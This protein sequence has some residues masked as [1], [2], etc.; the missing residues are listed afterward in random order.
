MESIFSFKKIT[1]EKVAQV[2]CNLNIRKSCWTTDIPTKVMK[3]NSD[4][5]PKF[6]YKHFN[7]CIHRG[8][9][10][11]ELKH[12]ELVLVHKENSK[13]DKENYR[14]V[15]ILS[16]PSKVYEKISYNQL[17]NYFENILFPSQCG[18]R[19]R[20][21]AQLYLLVMTEK[22]KEAIDRG[23]KFG[24]LLTDLS[25]AFHCIN[26]PLLIAKIDSYGVS[27]LSTKI[28]FP[29]LSNRT[30]RTKIK[31]SFIKRSNILHGVPQG[32]ILGPLLFNIDLIDLFYE[33]EESDIDG[34]DNTTS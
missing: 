7:Y 13:C 29:Y 30:Q 9:F 18:F 20:Y 3:L 8:E 25:K 14:P 24:A 28:I 31:N 10:P 5:L 15:S 33:C 17:C 6:I 27:P 23:D 26:Y 2:N 22:F 16:I 12:A 19:K 32:A 34:Y 1:P 21:S 4:I 11:N